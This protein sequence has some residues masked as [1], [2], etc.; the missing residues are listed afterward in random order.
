MALDL[1]VLLSMLE[2]KGQVTTV[3][4][5]FVVFVVVWVTFGFVQV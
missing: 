5:L 4:Y 3:G 1:G 2:D